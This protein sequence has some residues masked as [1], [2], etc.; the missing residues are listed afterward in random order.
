MYRYMYAVGHAVGNV[1]LF[2]GR[3]SFVTGKRL[4]VYLNYSMD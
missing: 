4:V 3:D 2:L 1:S